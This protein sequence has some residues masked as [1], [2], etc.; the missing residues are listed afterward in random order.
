MS[1]FSFRP[2]AVRG[3]ARRGFTLVELL[4][5][6]A[7]IGVLVGLL[8]PAVQSAREAA[9]R[10]SCLNNMKQ[11]ALS[12]HNF[13]D[14]NKKFPAVAKFGQDGPGKPGLQ[15][16]AHYTWLFY[17]LPYIE[18][19][20]AYDTTNQD[21]PV[22]G[23]PIVGY[24]TPAFLCPSDS[25]TNLPEDTHGI[26]VSHYGAN[27][28][29]HWWNGSVAPGANL[30]AGVDYQG[31]FNGDRA[32][33]MAQL[34]DGT[35]KT[36]MF[37]EN[38]STGYKGVRNTW[39]ANNAGVQRNTGG[40]QVFRC[41]F[42]GVGVHG[43]CCEAGIYS[44]PDNSG[45]M[46]AAWFRAGPHSYMPYYINAWGI[47]SEWP[48]AGGNHPGLIGV[49]MG[50]GSSRFVQVDIEYPIWCALNGTQDGQSVSDQ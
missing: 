1:C 25:G 20:A 37:A 33:S 14:T 15:Q 24:R 48:G 9:R 45:A 30:P 28:G 16:A 12:L 42:L 8:L 6:I 27:G 11:T 34:K 40:E 50:D 47:N 46:S 3:G 23:Q 4:V 13:H 7:I 18:E 19:Q 10:T 36:V 5:V 2:S 22:W 21:L 26:A 44:K 17:L 35:S 29:W 39:M 49:G 38:N 31:V 43:I 32:K 41:A